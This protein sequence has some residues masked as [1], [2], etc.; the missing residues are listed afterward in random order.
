MSLGLV[1]DFRVRSETGSGPVVVSA[2]LTGRVIEII[3]AMVAPGG[4]TRPAAGVS[5]RIPKP[6]KE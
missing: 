5:A 2:K 3:S 4:D 6:E 1:L